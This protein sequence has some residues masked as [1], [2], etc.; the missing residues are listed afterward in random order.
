MR[1]TIVL[2]VRVFSFFIGCVR[3][4]YFGMHIK[5][6]AGLL[7][8]PGASFRA[9]ATGSETLVPTVV[10]MRQGARPR[11]DLNYQQK[12]YWASLGACNMPSPT[13]TVLAA[14]R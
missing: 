11:L 6:P 10:F 14:S 13:F 4:P 9:I 12:L 3:T 2:Y 1:Q 7:E 5:P 8:L